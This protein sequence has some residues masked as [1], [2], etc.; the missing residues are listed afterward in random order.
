MRKWKFTVELLESR[1][2]PAVLTV[3]PN[4]Q[5]QTI[6]AAVN[7]A[8]PGDTVLID[9]GVYTEQVHITGIFKSNITLTAVVSQSAVVQAPQTMTGNDA[10]IEVDIATGVVIDGLTLTGKQANGRVGGVKDGVLIR[11][12]GSAT[13]QN[14][15]IT[16][17]IFD[18][19]FNQGGAIASINGYSVQV[20]DNTT[21]GTAVIKDST[22]DNY[23]KGGVWVLDL[24]SSR[25]SVAT[26]SNDM[27]TGVGATAATAQFGVK[28]QSGAQATI[29]H[30]SISANAYTGASGFGRGINITGG[31]AGNINIRANTIDGCDIGVS[32]SGTSGATVDSNNLS[33][34]NHD[35]LDLTASTT[36]ATV[37]S[38]TLNNN[39]R[40]G[41][42][43]D[44]TSTGNIFFF[45]TARGNN[46][47]ANG[48]FD[49]ED[50]STGG[51][52][53]GTGNTW[54]GDSFGTTSPPGLP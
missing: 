18:S 1:C 32:I 5:F 49:A 16:Q 17:I 53:N 39:G 26:V 44:S 4:E 28:V 52:T 25:P 7:A 14:S 30:N 27:I 11:D 10:L 46:A 9:P 40:D 13:V 21:P 51:G 22:L 3:G 47:L 43:V 33:N 6:Q 41:I 23:Q 15:H 19:T 45:N 50:Q 24:N 36:G 8:N 35:G 54:S 2:T 34:N 37:S 48:G 38:N 20:G 12:S 42:F 31:A 29:D